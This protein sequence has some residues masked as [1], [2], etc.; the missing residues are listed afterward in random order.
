[1]FDYIRYVSNHYVPSK[2]NKKKLKHL[3][4]AMPYFLPEEYQDLFF[5]LIHTY[6]LDCYWDSRATLQDYGYLLYSSFY[7]SLRQSYKSRDNYRFEPEESK[8]DRTHTMIFFSLVLIL[9]FI[10][11]LQ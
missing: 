4:E 7:Q 3:F 11:Y 8:Q 2:P 6:P 9:L 10:F 1:M 5:K